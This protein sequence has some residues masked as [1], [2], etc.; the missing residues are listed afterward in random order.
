MQI[1]VLVATITGNA[2]MIAE[3]VADSVGDDSISFDINNMD[4]DSYGVII[5]AGLLLLVSSTYGV[6]DVPDNG[7]SV[8][9]KLQEEKPDLSN[10]R[11]GAIGLGDSTYADSFAF[12]G[13]KWDAILTELGATR[14]GELLIL[15][16]SSADDPTDLATSW[17]A[18]WISLIKD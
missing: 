14:I 11:Y 18:D 16:A 7:I 1:P 4:D 5:E 8:Y 17:A 15:D 10:L 2:E 13:R 6:G 12:G 3:D 9:E